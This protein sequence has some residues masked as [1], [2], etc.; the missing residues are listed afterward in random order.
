MNR[1]QLKQY[2]R[3][4]ATG[5]EARKKQKILDGLVKAY[6][7]KGRLTRPEVNKAS[8]GVLKKKKKKY[9]KPQKYCWTSKLKDTITKKRK[10]ICVS[11]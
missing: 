7:E 9:S 8:G 4:P 2:L 10:K 3:T 11:K 1:S 5:A 6:K